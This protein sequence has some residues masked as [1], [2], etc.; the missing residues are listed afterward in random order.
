[1]K[2]SYAITVCN[3][4]LEIQRLITFL[5][6]NKRSQDEIVVQMDL[7]LEDLKNQPEDKNQ[8]FAYI[9]KHQEQGHI[10]VILS[11]LNGHFA[12][13]KN[14]LTEQCTGD[15]IFQIDADEIPSEDLIQALPE[16]L[17]LNPEMDIYLVP[18]VNTVEGLTPEHIAK[19]GWNVTDTGWV[20]WPDFQWRI[21]RNVPEIKWVNK[22]H[23]RLD[24]FKTYTMLPD[25][26]YFALYHPKTIEKQEK[27]N[28]LYDQI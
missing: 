13:F 6:K 10:R 14:H 28:Q 26:E 23:E 12:N 9:M 24:G 15:Y 3:E 11:P 17:E 25:V 21:W 4:F 18:R 22:V 5:L 19:W 2:I 8:V 1:M 7:N 27:Q 20:N 16:I